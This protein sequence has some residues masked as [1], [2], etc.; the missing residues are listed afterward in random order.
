M[1]PSAGDSPSVLVAE[2]VSWVQRFKERQV[3]WGAGVAVLGPFVTLCGGFVFYALA[4]MHGEY[5]LSW[6]LLH[7]VGFGVI[8]LAW[9][10]PASLVAFVTGKKGFA[11][12]LLVG[13]GALLAANALAWVVGLAI[14]PR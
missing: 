2:P 14:G 7:I 5:S 10:L 3:Q 9:L 8:Q 12:G 13:G 11:M 1:L 6:M 4:G